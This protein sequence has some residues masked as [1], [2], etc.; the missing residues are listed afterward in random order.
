MTVRIYN[1]TSKALTFAGRLQLIQSVLF[2]IQVHW[3]LVFILPKKILKQVDRI[4]RNFLWTGPDLSHRGAKVAWENITYPKSEGGLGIKKLES[5]NKACILKNIWNICKS[6]LVSSW[7]IWAK[8]NLL[9][10]KSFWDMKMPSNCSWTW[11][12][13][14]KLRN[15]ARPH[16]QYIIGDR[17]STHLW[18]DH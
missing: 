7:A 16:I 13:L 6:T 3:S 10:N 9:P 1:W 14:L 15:I 5:W 18:F 12:K 8:A 2:N 17:Q 11:R 4:L